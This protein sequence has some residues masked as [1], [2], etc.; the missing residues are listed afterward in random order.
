[1]DFRFNRG[2][3]LDS[4]PE[5]GLAT[6]LAAA[7]QEDDYDDDVNNTLY[8]LTDLQ[9]YTARKVEADDIRAIRNLLKD[10]DYSHFRFEDPVLL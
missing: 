7:G 3:S 10:D 5:P 6:G 1:M 4:A 8:E 9:E 2:G